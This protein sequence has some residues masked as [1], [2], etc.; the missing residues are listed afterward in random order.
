MFLRFGNVERKNVILLPYKT[1]CRR[2]P[3]NGVLM[4]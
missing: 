4:K 3:G 2:V 1:E